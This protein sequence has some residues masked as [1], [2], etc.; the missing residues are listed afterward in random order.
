MGTDATRQDLS[1]EGPFNGIKSGQDVQ[2]AGFWTEVAQAA[3]GPSSQTL[4]RVPNFLALLWAHTGQAEDGVQVGLRDACILRNRELKPRIMNSSGHCLFL[5]M[6]VRR[7]L[8][9]HVSSSKGDSLRAGHGITAH[10]Q[11]ADDPGFFI[12]LLPSAVPI[13]L[14]AMCHSEIPF[15]F[16][17][18]QPCRVG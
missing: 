9:H 1:K 11:K 4:L 6:Q 5:G 14:D 2:R 17:P 13:S 7:S 18:Q 10:D 15:P 3:L 12:S 8:P 16:L